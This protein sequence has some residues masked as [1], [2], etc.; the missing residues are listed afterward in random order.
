MEKQLCKL[1]WHQGV[2]Q[3]IPFCPA[4]QPPCCLHPRSCP[5]A[6]PQPRGSAF[7]RG[8]SS[9][10]IC[11][12]VKA[13]EK[14]WPG[15]C[16]VRPGSWQ[17]P[18]GHIGVQQPTMS[19]QNRRRFPK[20]VTISI[21]QGSLCTM[22]GPSLGELAHQKPLASMDASS[23]GCS[24]EVNLPGDTEAGQPWSRA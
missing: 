6:F 23:R 12:L 9:E 11:I 18:P 20:Q 5:G 14:Q 16:S 13:T 10:H 17:H 3:D 19:H 4:H 15:A 7:P 8:V 22:A 21:S 1:C 2:R 24:E